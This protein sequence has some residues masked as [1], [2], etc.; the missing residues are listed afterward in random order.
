MTY[1]T[2]PIKRY[3]RTKQEINSIRNAIYLIL[4]LDNPMT[5]RQ[6]FYRLVSEGYIG[7]TD[8]EYKNLV[9]RLLA[10]MRRNGGVP[11]SWV[12]DSTR[13]VRKPETFNSLSSFFRQGAE[14]YRRALW[15]ETNI[16]I[17]IWVE[18]DTLSGVLYPVTAQYDVPI[19]VA[20]GF[21]S[22]T[23]LQNNAQYIRECYEAGKSVFIY[24]FGDHDPSG[25]AASLAVEK[26]LKEFS[27]NTPFHYERVAVTPQHI[28]EYNLPTR[29]TK[30]TDSRAKNFNGES[31]E[32]E[33]IPAA[34]LRN[35]CRQVIEQ[36]IDEDYL[37]EL[38][39]AESYERELLQRYSAI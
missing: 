20:R 1:K 24:Q 14:M 37:N 31:V 15:D 11:F 23:F 26:G 18:K 38:L 34:E 6:V 35:M 7:K 12:A 28:Q 25:V 19:M 16:H 4:A 27:D 22:I 2:S 3:R 10:D 9:V 5:V 32:I 36:H 29:P 21:S 39:H 8:N 33:A 17:E 13:L 30:K